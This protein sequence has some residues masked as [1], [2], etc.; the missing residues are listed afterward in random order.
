MTSEPDAADKLIL[1][2]DSRG[3]LAVRGDGEPVL[4]PAG[5]NGARHALAGRLD[6]RPVLAVRVA[7]EDV[8][9][10][11]ADEDAEVGN[12]VSSSHNQLVVRGAALLGNQARL[13]FRPAD[14]S[15]LVYD[16]D[17]RVAFG[18]RNAE[19]FPRIDPA[20]I[21]LINLRG[22]DKVLIAENKRRPGLFTLVAGYVEAGE[23]LEDA[24][25]R[26][27]LEETGRRI[28]DIRYLASQ[29]WPASGSLMVGFSAQTE[30]ESAVQDTDGELLTTR[31]VSR[32]EVAAQP[33]PGRGSIAHRIL[34][35]FAE[36]AIRFP[37][38]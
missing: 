37:D 3:R 6:G 33:L 12:I 17:G 18:K 2:I 28:S 9:S 35:S 15:T 14:A 30:D 20:V 22:T 7:P 19:V 11:A 27:A 5:T 23:E 29:A 32:G 16:D 1:A 38:E 36:G 26:E 31:W 4:R 24:F 34:T 13:R 8:D 25:A 10:I 21:G